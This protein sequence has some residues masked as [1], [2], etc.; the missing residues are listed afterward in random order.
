MVLK[1]PSHKRNDPRSQKPQ[2]DREQRQAY[3][4]PFPAKNGAG[5]KYI[6]GSA[7]A[8][9]KDCEHVSSHDAQALLE[10]QI[11][12]TP[13][14]QEEEEE[15]VESYSESELEGEGNLEQSAKLSDASKISKASIGP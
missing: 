2:T 5:G 1:E 7:N 4:K 6:W 10:S 9:K 8:D 3:S 14:D 11:G 13:F 12:E 15:F